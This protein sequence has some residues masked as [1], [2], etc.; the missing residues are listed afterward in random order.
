MVLLL[1]HA[2]ACCR[3]HLWLQ[4]LKAAA[5]RHALQRWQQVWGLKQCM[6]GL[7]LLLEGLRQE[8]L[9]CCQGLLLW[10]LALL[11]ETREALLLHAL[12]WDALRKALCWKA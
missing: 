6:R 8:L 11:L 12:L 2:V 4:W 10:L 1:W 9:Q 3:Q 5:G 7:H